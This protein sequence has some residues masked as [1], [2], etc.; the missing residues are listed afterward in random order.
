MIVPLDPKS[1]VARARQGRSDTSKGCFLPNHPDHRTLIYNF[2]MACYRVSGPRWFG[3]YGGQSIP[4]GGGTGPGAL[5]SIFALYTYFFA[6][7]FNLLGFLLCHCSYA[8]RTSQHLLPVSC[9]LS[10]HSGKNWNLG[11]YVDLAFVIVLLG[12]GE[13]SPLVE[14]LIC[15]ALTRDVENLAT[16]GFCATP[17]GCKVSHHTISPSF[18]QVAF[19]ESPLALGTYEADIGLP[20]PTPLGL[21]Q[22]RSVGCGV[23]WARV[24]EIPGLNTRDVGLQGVPGLRCAESIRVSTPVLCSTETSIHEHSLCLAVFLGYKYSHSILQFHSIH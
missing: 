7:L 11:G 18:D 10:L 12:H 20:A 2:Q 1:Y 5:G 13:G 24:P 14:P 6:R 21:R 23:V 4:S 9:Q 8:Y 15:A 16:G 22:S 3:W 17:P 19:P